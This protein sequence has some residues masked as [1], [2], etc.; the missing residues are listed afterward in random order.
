MIA[1]RS[2]RV[3]VAT[4][5]VQRPDAGP[6]RL[7]PTERAL[8]Q[9]L[10][11]HPDR[12]LSRR[13]LLTEV[14]GY[15]P[16]ITS[17]T[18][19]TTV[20]T[21]RRKI[22][23]DPTAPDHLLTAWGTGY[24]FT[25]RTETPTGPESP[26]PAALVG[27]SRELAAIEDALAGGA[28]WVTL[29]GP[30][31][32]GK[33]RLALELGRRRVD[34]R[35]VDLG[36]ATDDGDVAIAAGV[37]VDGDPSD[38]GRALVL[39]DNAEQVCDA[40]R[41]LV[42]GWLAASAELAVVVT[43]R[44]PLGGAEERV[45]RVDPLG[46]EDALTLLRARAELARPGSSS[47][48]DRSLAAIVAAVE[49]LPL[50]IELAA[51]RLTI[52]SASELASRWPASELLRRRSGPERHRS[53]EAVVAW[54]WD[55]LEPAEQQLL[56]ACAVFAGGFTVDLAE[57]VVGP[58]AV[59]GASVVDRLAALHEASLVASRAVGSE[60]RLAL[61][62]AVRRFAEARLAD[63]GPLWARCASVLAARLDGAPVAALLVER[64]NLIA[65]LRRPIPAADAARIALL[66]ERSYTSTGPVSAR[67][68][69]AERAV[70]AAR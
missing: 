26:P 19:D 11:D 27:R 35:W 1:L 4:G 48:A 30:G 18:L 55:L 13:E 52:L 37:V 14:W 47:G 46:P 62:E 36:A 38:L 40:V 20:K 50:A 60:V 66:L 34:A 23:R 10:V 16:S 12:D 51:A 25:A 24:R 6:S 43:S 5:Q 53:L 59:P 56:A 64:D 32:V 29:A 8:L 3:D 67:L 68:E 15:R 61:P 9:F 57:A 17:R 42:E 69:L 65:A 70:E 2:A 22:E 49:G 31:G 41:A 44:V 33:T 28:R 45:I 39:L 58:G 21:L 54:S 7:T 63:P